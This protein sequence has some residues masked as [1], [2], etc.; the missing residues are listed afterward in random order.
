[1]R[2]FDTEYA[3]ACESARHP[4]TAR[5]FRALTWLRLPAQRSFYRAQHETVFQTPTAPQILY[6]ACGRTQAGGELRLLLAEKIQ[7]VPL[8]ECPSLPALLSTGP[9]PPGIAPGHENP[10]HGCGDNSSATLS[11]L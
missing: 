11:A 7:S 4:R 10:A 6:R 2:L 8:A 1:M 3:A 9:P 5:S